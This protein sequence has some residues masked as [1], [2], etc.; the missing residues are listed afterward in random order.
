MATFLSLLVVLLLVT[1]EVMLSKVGVGNEISFRL[2]PTTVQLALPAA[3][4]L[5]VAFAF[6]LWS[7]LAG[8]LALRHL[9]GPVD[10]TALAALFL[11]GIL[12]VA[13]A[14]GDPALLRAVLVVGLGLGAIVA[15]W[16]VLQNAGLSQQTLHWAR[17]GGITIVILLAASALLGDTVLV[18]AALALGFA[19]AALATA[20]YTFVELRGGSRLETESRFG[21]LGGGLGGWRISSAASL[22]VL[23]VVL[24][25]AAVTL[26]TYN[27]S[28]SGNAVSPREEASAGPSRAST[29][30]P[31]KKGADHP[32][33]AVP[34]EQGS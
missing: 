1:V 8:G 31:A 33:A 24:T 9:R 16:Y 14:R 30:A 25:G 29:T 27:A 5:A 2:W 23:T 11:A 34:V 21:G 12:L 22:L 18:R 20:Y 10:W 28:R 4:A 32:G 6:G 7:M 13:A 26:A 15:I 3:V 17:L 19:T